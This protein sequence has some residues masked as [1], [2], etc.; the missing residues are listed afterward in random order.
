MKLSN[1]INP[2]LCIFAHTCI[3][4]RETH[5]MLSLQYTPMTSLI[6]DFAAYKSRVHV[7]PVCIWG[8]F[9]HL[10]QQ[11]MYTPQTHATVP[12]FHIKVNDTVW[13]RLSAWKKHMTSWVCY[14]SWTCDFSAYK[15][16]G[17]HG[18]VCSNSPSVS[19]SHTHT[20]ISINNSHE[21]HST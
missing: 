2:V 14:V 8:M 19:L 1:I 9:A 12:N 3:L 11:T 21:K 4:D 20:H 17:F 13:T 18:P 6:Y 10:T 16:H 5:E 7:G 15:R